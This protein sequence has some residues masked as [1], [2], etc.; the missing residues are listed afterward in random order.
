YGRPAPSSNSANVAT[1]TS[2]PR[3]TGAP[4]RLV[5]SGP[6]GCAATMPGRFDALATVPAA[7]STVPGEPTPMP[8][9]AL[10]STP[11]ARAASLSAGASALTTSSAPPT[12][13]V[14]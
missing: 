4:R 3:C 10:V 13:G 6:T 12:V 7:S 1:D 2:L 8:L 11:A 14:G 9:S 5:N